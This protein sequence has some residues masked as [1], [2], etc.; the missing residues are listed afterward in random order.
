V[1]DDLREALSRIGFLAVPEE[2]D[3]REDAEA[4]WKAHRTGSRRDWLREG[5]AAAGAEI[6]EPW[7]RE[8]VP[9][10]LDLLTHDDALVRGN[11]ARLLR[12]ISGRRLPVRPIARD[13]GSRRA[14]MERNAAIAVWRRWWEES[15]GK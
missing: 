6:E 1:R 7:D 12:E 2:V 8:D 11:A 5:F 15:R 10:L 3:T 13:S 9:E 4:W 14:T